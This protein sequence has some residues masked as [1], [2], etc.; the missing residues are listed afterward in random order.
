MSERFPLPQYQSGVVR[1]AAVDEMLAPVDSV[2]WA[3]NVHFDQIGAVQTRKG[4]TRL[5]SQISAG[6]PIL[7]MGFYRDNAG[8]TFAALAKINTEVYAYSGS[9]WT[10]VR[11]S[12]TA[13]SKARFTNFVDYTFMVNGHLNE[14]VQTWGGS[15][16]F[17]TTNAASLPKGDFIEN[18]RSRI[19][20]ADNLTDKLYY[21]DVVTTSNTI[22]GGTEFIQ[23]SPADGE[24]MTG[25]KRSSGALLV[26]KQN[27]IYRVYDIETTDPDPEINRG[28]YSQESIIEGKDGIYYHHPTGFYKFVNGPKQEEISRPIV[29]IVKAIP[30]SS[31]DDI[32]GWAD[33]DALYWS[34][35]DITLDGISFTNL[36][37]RR[38][39]STQVWTVYSRPTEIRSSV[40]YDSGTTLVPILGDNDGN[41]LQLNVGNDD[42]GTAIFYD[43]ITHWYYISTNR[44]LSKS[45]TELAALHE[46]MTGAQLSFQVDSQ[47][48]K[49]TNNA[50]QPI[51]SLTRS[52]YEVLSANANNFMRVR[53]RLSGST[54][55]SP[56]TFRGFEIL[57]LVTKGITKV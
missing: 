38:T 48:Q 7:G 41:V 5:G 39:I 10:S 4:L 13:S 49:K 55:G 14:I 1:E 18:F 46:N 27:H 44:G 33:D 12:L 52:I 9:S 15:G 51:G 30:R 19:W 53:F 28:T 31:Y 22:T 20:V 3:L 50:W 8:T 23:I 40:L 21:S 24:S 32:A 29:D 43:L 37:V 17:G 6:N 35:G 56:A 45:F 57:D 34:I 42:F 16:S 47:N 2:E 25:L 54:T 11:A 26:F 36:E